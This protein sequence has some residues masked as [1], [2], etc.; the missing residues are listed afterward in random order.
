MSGLTL[1]P[2]LTIGEAA[3]Y[4]GLHRDRITGGLNKRE[5]PAVF[6]E[7]RRFVRPNDLIVWLE[8]QG[9]SLMVEFAR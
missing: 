1:P 3:K 7:G 6:V 5:L 4:S 9:L 8:S 2:I